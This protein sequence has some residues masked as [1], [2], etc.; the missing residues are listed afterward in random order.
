MK[1]Y[2]L[3]I[4]LILLITVSCDKK[5]PDSNIKDPF[6]TN[7][8][9]F[10]E[11]DFF[12]DLE[13]DSLT[14]I[15][16]G[17]AIDWEGNDTELL[18]DAYFP[19]SEMDELSNRPAV[20]LIHGGGYQSGHK[21]DW[22]DECF[23]FAKKGFVAF[24]IKYRLGWDDNEPIDQF[25]ASYRANQDARAALRF[26]VDN[27]DQYGVN[28][29]W[30]FI[31]GGSA[32]AVSA[33]DIVY[34]TQDEWNAFFPGIEAALGNLDTSGNNLNNTYS[35][36]GVF[37]NW[38][39]TIEDYMQP[40]EMLPMISFH[41]E[42]DTTVPIDSG[43]QGFIGSRAISNTLEDNGI[44][45]DLTVEPDGEHGIYLNPLGTIFR[46]GRASCFFKSMMCDNCNN[47]YAEEVIEAN[48][49][50]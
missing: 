3:L 26:I 35:I 42:L 10:T 7:D 41:G 22:A 36:K 6:C 23:E 13:I 16:Y 28:T 48:C 29:D 9:R 45:F 17:N 50:N 18:I 19:D 20:M 47:F 2:Y 37:N 8:S 46:V 44:C 15:V 1:I 24:T 43:M 11:S 21:E 5:E 4:S 25:R 14:N 32:G 12:S 33:L 38:G 40:E 30:I 39:G 34:I 31:G 27:A 49:S